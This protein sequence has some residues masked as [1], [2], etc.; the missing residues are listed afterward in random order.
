MNVVYYSSDFFSEICGVAIESLCE[1]NQDAEHITIY[2]V[3]DQIADINKARLQ[4][5]AEHFDRE[6]VFIKAP[7]QEEVYPGIKMNLG[8]TFTRM[9]LGEILPPE[10]DRVLS[11]DSD[12]LVMDS[13]REMY[14]T[15]FD[16]DEFVAGVYDCLGKAMQKRVL[17]APDDMNYCNAGVFLIDLNKWRKADM[18]KKLEQAVR[19]IADGKHVMY[20][21]EQ[22]LM[23][24]LFYGHLKLLHPR[25]NLLTSIYLFDYPEM[26]MMKKPTAYYQKDEI[27]AA[28]NHPA[29][30]HATTCFYVRKRM[31]VKDSDHPY[32]AFYM[33]FRSRTPWKDTDPIHDARTGKKKIYSELWHCMP[34]KWAVRMAAFMI[35]AV[36]PLYAWI[37]AKA[38]ITTVA[39]QSST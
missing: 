13:L 23:N 16:D 34:R 10:V 19:D 24:L 26:M 5:I 14:E 9:I 17:H 39:N 35:N 37:T 31:W 15:D 8:K 32:A 4:K 2:I 3:E 27:Q 33:D 18:G 6:I 22:D 29:L 38:S 1:N 25:Y 20:F 11:L 7:S 30:L 36:R 12:T 28:K 21:L